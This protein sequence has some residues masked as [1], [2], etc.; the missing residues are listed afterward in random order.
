[1]WVCNLCGDLT[2]D[3]V[4]T[5]CRHVFCR[6]CFD[7]LQNMQWVIKT[8]SS[9]TLIYSLYLNYFARGFVRNAQLSQVIYILYLYHY[10]TILSK[11][12]YFA[13]NYNL[14]DTVTPQMLKMQRTYFWRLSSHPSWSRVS[15]INC[16]NFCN[17]PYYIENNQIGTL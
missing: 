12:I 6:P 9:F 5:P 8:S 4:V 15:P 14:L 1:M 10:T 7:N 13:V 16:I 2:H 11:C 17:L 3:Q